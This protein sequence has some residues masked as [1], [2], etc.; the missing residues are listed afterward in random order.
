MPEPDLQALRD[1]LAVPAL[2]AYG[3]RQ[4]ATWWSQ[5]R[6]QKYLDLLAALP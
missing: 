6:S 2:R 3:R 1:V 4:L 5:E